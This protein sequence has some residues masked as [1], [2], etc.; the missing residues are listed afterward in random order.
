M[1][2]G[3]LGTEDATAA[4]A[5]AGAPFVLLDAAVRPAGL[6]ARE[7]GLPLHWLIGPAGADFGG[8]TFSAAHLGGGVRAAKPLAPVHL[9]ARPQ[10]SGDVAIRWI[11]RGRIAADSWEPAEI[12]LGEE[13]EAYRVEI[14][15]PAG[16]VV[17][18]AETTV[19]HW[20]YP[21]ADIL[22][23]F[24]TT[25]AEVDILVMQKKGLA[26]APGLRALLRTEIG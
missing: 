26:G 12:P 15:N 14:R 8:S 13:A 10:P 20:T 23:D 11:R 17:R 7:V 2:R 22:A 18:A 9:A 4:G 24:A 5:S 6:R 16:A 21:A 3:Q 1:L 19:P 25:P